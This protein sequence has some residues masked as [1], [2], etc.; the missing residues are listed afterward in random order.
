[1]L[2]NFYISNKLSNEGNVTVNNVRNL[3]EGYTFWDDYAFVIMM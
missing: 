3:D 1:M 2:L